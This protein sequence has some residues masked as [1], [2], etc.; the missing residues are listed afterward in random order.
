MTKNLGSEEHGDPVPMA[1]LSVCLGLFSSR[2]LSSE[3]NREDSL[4]SESPQVTFKI[5]SGLASEVRQ[6]LSI[7]V[8]LRSNP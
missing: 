5:S 1:R 3:K 7:S 6:F 4:S 2:Q 8:L